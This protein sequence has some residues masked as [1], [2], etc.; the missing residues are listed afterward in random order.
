MRRFGHRKVSAA[1]RLF[2]SC[3]QPPSVCGVSVRSGERRV[4]VSGDGDDFGSAP[5]GDAAPVPVPCSVGDAV[6]RPRLPVP[7][8][9]DG[10]PRG[11]AVPGARPVVPEAVLRIRLPPP[12]SPTG[13]STITTLP[14]AGE[15]GRPFRSVV[16]R[17]DRY[18]VLPRPNSSS[19]SKPGRPRPRPATRRLVSAGNASGPTC[20]A[21]RRYWRGG[22]EANAAFSALD[23]AGGTA[24]HGRVHRRRGHEGGRPGHRRLPDPDARGP[25]PGHTASATPSWPGSAPPSNRPSGRIR[26]PC[27]A[28]IPKVSGLRTMRYPISAKGPVT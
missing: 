28:A 23:G 6:C 8:V 2:R 15:T 20:A 10:S 4:R 11:V 19:L 1:D 14:D 3:L 12:F 7:A 24:A 21:G 13:R 16:A 18:P 22:A 26:I 27:T 9:S 17:T 25:V 5:G